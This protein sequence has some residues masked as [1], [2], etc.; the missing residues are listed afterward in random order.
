MTLI[1]LSPVNQYLG[2]AGQIR[3][4]DGVAFCGRAASVCPHAGR[5]PA[6]PRLAP[7]CRHAFAGIVAP[8]DIPV[9]R[10]VM[11]RGEPEHGFERD[12][13]VE[14]PIV[15]E[16]KLVEIGV[17]VLAA[18]PMIGAEPP[19]LHQREDPMNPGQHDVAGHL[20]DRPRV[21]PVIGEPG[22]GSVPVGEQRRSV[23]TLARTKASIEAAELSGIAAR[24]IRPDRVSR[25][26]ARFRLGLAWFVPRSITSTA[27]AIRIFPDFT[28]SKKLLSVRKGISV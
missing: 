21:V 13:P 8:D 14:A 28:G 4:G 6:V 15:S 24:R 18:Q 5:C 26:F 3:N 10:R 25:Y 7:D 12:V 19:T 27:P 22:I 9:T 20:A 2:L 1:P 23:F 16:D 17:E 11:V